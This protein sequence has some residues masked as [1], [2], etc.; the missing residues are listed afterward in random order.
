M[1]D[2]ERYC[3]N[4]FH[5]GRPTNDWL[6]ICNATGMLK[7]S[8]DTCRSFTTDEEGDGNDFFDY[9]DDEYDYDDFDR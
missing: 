5:F 2:V 3:G 8:L 6:C 7:C 9:D 4:C 1:S